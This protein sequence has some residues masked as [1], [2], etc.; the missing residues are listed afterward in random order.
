MKPKR[1]ALYFLKLISFGMLGSSR[2]KTNAPGHPQVEKLRTTDIAY[3]LWNI[4]QQIRWLESTL[5][6]Q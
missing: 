1:W 6:T 3:V 4:T 5:V 2:E